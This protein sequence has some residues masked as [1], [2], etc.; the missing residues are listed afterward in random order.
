MMNQEIIILLEKLPK[1]KVTES[2][3]SL[4]LKGSYLE[5][6]FATFS[7]EE[8]YENLKSLSLY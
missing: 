4:N 3:Q 5:I 1:T 6:K 7:D 8:S 2:F